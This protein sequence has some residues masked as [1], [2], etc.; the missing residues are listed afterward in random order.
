V[1]NEV[2]GPHLYNL[3]ALY[4]HEKLKAV[5]KGLVSGGKDDIPEIR[6]GVILI[7]SKEKWVHSV[8]AMSRS[9]DMN[10][11]QTVLIE[12]VLQPWP[13]SIHPRKLTTHIAQLR[14]VKHR[15]RFLGIKRS[16]GPPEKGRI[17]T[18]AIPV[19]AAV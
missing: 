7:Q 3:F 15:R 14:K 16:Q 11:Q 19:I 13:Q 18:R 1:E 5:L 17:H 8:I 2:H 10:K 4:L 6:E 9:G 12:I